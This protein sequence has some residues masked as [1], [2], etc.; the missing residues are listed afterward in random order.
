LQHQEEQEVRDI[1]VELVKYQA[2]DQLVE[3]EAAVAKL[4]TPLKKPSEETE[5]VD[6]LVILQE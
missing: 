4:D 5:E 1:M 3:V 2:V 6:I